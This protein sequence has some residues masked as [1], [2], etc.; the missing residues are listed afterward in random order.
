[1]ETI[2]ITANSNATRRTRNR[3]K[4]NGTE[5]THEMNGK[6]Q[7]WILVHS[8]RT[9]WFGWLPTNEIKVE[10]VCQTAERVL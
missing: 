1:M 5:F 8:T 7:G 6:K 10:K 9:D 3:V 4:E 2:T